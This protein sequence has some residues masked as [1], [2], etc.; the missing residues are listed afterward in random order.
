MLMKLSHLKQ[1]IVYFKKFEKIGAIYRVSDTIIKVVFDRDDEVYFDMQRSNSAVFKCES[2][3]RSKVYNAPFDVVLAKR[4][5]RCEIEDV[6]LVK[7]DKIL[8]FATVQKGA[9]KEIKTY[10]QF[11]FTGKYTNVIILDEEERVLEALRH[12]DLF[13]SFREVKVGQKLLPPPAAPFAARE[14]PI[15]DIEKF[16]YDVYSERSE[17]RLES[18]KKQKLSFLQKKLSRLEKFY[19]ELEDESVLER[20]VRE[21]EHFGNLIL[22]NLH[23]IKPYQKLLYVKDYDG[24][25]VQI[26]LDTLF[27]VPSDIAKHFFRLSKKAKQKARNLHIERASLEEKMEF[28]KHFIQTVKNA[29]DISRIE[30][31]FPAK[32]QEK[33]TKQNESIEQFFIDGYKVML[34]KSEKGNIELL[35]KA[36]AKDTWLH[37]KDRPSAHVIIVTDKQ[38][39][40]QHIIYEAARLCVDFSL[41]EKGRYLVD[42]TQRREVKIQDGANVLYYKYNTIEVDN[43]L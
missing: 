25:D 11:E 37:L 33:R 2:Y 21:N 18:L 22:S 27:A 30:L 7:G 41:F 28:L 24:S 20:E 29:R 6:A 19:D 3:T 42:Y 38:S 43:T 13:S 8:R 5:N 32:K 31:L 40:P 34:G 26:G 17:K 36:K 16:L 4:F 12:I 14:Y 23:L 35:Q 15:E 1:L 39:L 10:L 9:Y